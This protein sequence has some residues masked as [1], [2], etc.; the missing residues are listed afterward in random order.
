MQQPG[1]RNAMARKAAKAANTSAREVESRLVTLAE[2]VG[3]FAGTAWNKADN[4]IDNESLRE[5]LTQLRD[6]AS[7][8]LDQLN[9]AAAAASQSAGKAAKAAKSSMP[10]AAAR[11]AEAEKKA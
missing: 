1:R 10:G 8:M 4:L 5:Q 9:R 7:T 3:W 11:R 6:S 2:Q